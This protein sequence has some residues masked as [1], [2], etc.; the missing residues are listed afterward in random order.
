MNRNFK[1]VAFDLD[2]TLYP[3]YRLNFRLIPFALSHGPLL[4]AFAQA[5]N[6]IR[7][8]QAAQN[9][10]LKTTNYQ[11]PTNFYDLQAQITAKIL[12]KP[13]ELIKEKIDRLI[14]TGW[15][16]FFT[17]IKLFPHAKEILDE[18]RAEKIKIGL[19]SDFPTRVKL[20]NL[21]LSGCWDVVLCSEDCGALKPARRPFEE[22]ARALDCPPE[23]ILYVG[24]SR[25][26]DAG[27]AK[28]AG[29]KTALKTGLF[30]IKKPR[31]VDFAFRDYR[32]LREYIL[33]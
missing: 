26:Y 33:H 27:G 6:I 10:S 8:E 3:E 17:K 16:P 1:A 2:G 18:L 14:Y 22:L 30:T 4:A 25:L 29:M 24:N 19:L 28:R 15:T 7:K 13:P 31:N 23:K 5:R 20:E 32:I 9:S 12:K 11:L 21:G